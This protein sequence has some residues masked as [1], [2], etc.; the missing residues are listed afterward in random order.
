MLDA[1]GGYFSLE[2]NKSEKYPFGD[3]IHLN[4]ARNCIEYILRAKEYQKVFLPYYTCDVVLEPIIKL[5][6]EF[7]FFDVDDNLEA[8]FDFNKLNSKEVIILNNYFGI[9]TAYIKKISTQ[10]QNLIVDNAQALYSNDILGADSV[11]SPRK[12]VGVADGGL[13]SCNV[14]LKEEFETD[15]SYE[16]MSH[17]LKRIDLNAEKSYSDF[18]IND[19]SLENNTIK[20]MSN[21]TNS[22]LKAI[23]FDKIKDVRINNFNYI[24]HHLKKMNTLNL[25]LSNEC[26]PMIYPFRT[27]KAELLKKKLIENR[28]YCATY[29]PNVLNW[30]SEK[31][32]S[33]NLTKEIIALPIDQR[34]DDE[35]MNKILEI[36]KYV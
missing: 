25:D 15:L 2:L 6:I 14:L 20:K 31:H 17:L 27:K 23:D 26:V 5:N 33:Y 32:N 12:F 34:Y 36:I 4:S 1:I 19:K 11:Y 9:K 10:L 28:I 3:F 8:I 16:R 18:S 29:W 30:C 22:I 24:H 13:L 7:E 35:S 21:L